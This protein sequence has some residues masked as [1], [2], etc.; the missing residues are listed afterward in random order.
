MPIYAPVDSIAFEGF[1]YIEEG[2]T[3]YSVFFE[4]TCDVFYLYEHILKP[5][6]KL[7]RAFKREPTEDDTR[8]YDVQQV[9]RQRFVHDR[10]ETCGFR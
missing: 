8:T 9:I 6:E 10:F 7:K 3:Q 1:T 5:V 4:V 2:M